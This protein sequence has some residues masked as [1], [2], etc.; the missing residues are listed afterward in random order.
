M[1]LWGQII[2]TGVGNPAAGADWS[3]TVQAGHFWTLL[4]LNAV[5]ATS[6]VGANRSPRLLIQDG[7]GN[8]VGLWG[9][10]FTQVASQTLNYTAPGVV[11]GQTDPNGT[12]GAIVFPLPA[13]LC[14]P[15]GFTVSVSTRN[16]QAADQWSA[17][18]FVVEDNAS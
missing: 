9:C 6:A 18:N 2:S 11:M 1:K 17:I 5:L 10:N 8:T 16:L 12:F 13:L 15:G 3:V 4:S 7:G 14:L